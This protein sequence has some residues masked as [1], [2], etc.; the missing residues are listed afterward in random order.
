[1]NAEQKNSWTHRKDKQF[2]VT[3]PRQIPH[4]AAANM[5]SS[6]RGF[7]EHADGIG[8]RRSVI[9]RHRLS[10]DKFLMW[11]GVS[12]NTTQRSHVCRLRYEFLTT[13]Y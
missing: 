7:I 5:L 13:P 8:P 6:F 3:L 12:S 4:D 9:Y 11:F 2:E 10:G 1:M